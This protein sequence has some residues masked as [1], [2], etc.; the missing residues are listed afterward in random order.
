MP[1]Y[2]SMYHHLAGRVAM[3]TEVSESMSK[4]LEAAIQT[5]SIISDEFA[6]LSNKMKH[7]QQQTEEIFINCEEKAES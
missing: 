6:V 5:L 3:I 2:K 4:S 7:A 1:D